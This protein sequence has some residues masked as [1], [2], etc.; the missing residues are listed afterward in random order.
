MPRI[1]E[2]RFYDGA[3]QRIER[4]GLGELWSELEGVL[5]G[6]PLLILEEKDANGGAAVRSLIDSR[7]E[8]AKGWDKLQSGGVD[9]TKCVDSDGVRRC[10]GVEIQFSARSDLLIVDVV[11]LRDKITEGD[12]DVGVLVVPS[13]KLSRFMTDRAPRFKD[14][15]TAI[16]RARAQDLPLAILALEHDGPGPALEKRKTRQGKPS[17]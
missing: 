2:R 11:H 8:A 14:A 13:D 4:L 15:V 9:W 6:F 5:S 12:V 1:V 7:F 16:E 3:K 17:P 10:F